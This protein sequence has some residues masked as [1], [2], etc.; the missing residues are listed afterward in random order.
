[1]ALLASAGLAITLYLIADAGFAEVG[2]AFTRAGWG[3]A[4]IV[5]YDVSGLSFAGLAWFVLLRPFWR[6]RP[7]LF[8]Y[9]RWLREAINNMLPVAQ[10]GG[11][12]VGARLLTAH[13]APANLSVAGI[14]A[15]KTIETVDQFLFTIAG[16]VLFLGRS[17]DAGLGGSLGLGLVIAAPLL[18]TFVA[19]QNSRLFAGFERLL[20]KLA[21]RMRWEALGRIEG[22]H[23][24]LASLYTEPVGLA[25]SFACHMLAWVAGAGQVWLALH[26]M[27]H[28]IAFR[29]A[30]ILESLGQA[31]RSAAFLIPG[32]L[33]AQEGAFLLI[34]HAIGLPAD[35]ALALSLIK[36]TSQLLFGLPLLAS[37]PFF[38]S[39]R[40]APE[41][42]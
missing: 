28:P 12:V 18:F 1:V 31:A 8:I 36:R 4:L 14:L 21:D 38:R 33:G 23:A 41:V 3:I 9:F 11:D 39:A 37:W 7:F 13:G 35:Y 24:A 34:G 19:I 29:D 2:D 20:L 6:G 5:L 17:G 22:M 26:F 10:V 40:A 42:P 15:D 16:F 27:G 25:G 32:G 30:F